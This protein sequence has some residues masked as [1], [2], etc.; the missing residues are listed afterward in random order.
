MVGALP[1]GRGHEWFVKGIGLQYSL[2]FLRV[3]LIFCAF[4]ISAP[5]L[6]Q[7][8]RVLF[9]K[10]V[11]AFQDGEFDEAAQTLEK[12][13]SSGY[14]TASLH[15]NLGVVYFR[16][17]RYRQS[18][19]AF[20]RLLDS[21]DER[22]ARYNLGLVA[23]ASGEN[24]RA[25]QQFAVVYRANP[26]DKLGRLSRRQLAEIGYD[27]E[28]QDEEKRDWYLL[29]AL[30]AG[31]EENIARLPDQGGTQ[32]DSGFGEA[33]LAGG[34]FLLG[35]PSGGL[36]ADASV[37]S[38]RYPG[39]EG[40]NTAAGQ[41]EIGWSLGAGDG[42]LRSGLGVIWYRLAGESRERRTR[43]ALRYR[44][45]GC[46]GL[47]RLERCQVRLT[48]DEIY[49][50]RGLRPYEGTRYAARLRYRAYW[51]AWRLGLTY[52]AIVNNREDFLASD[53]FISLSPRR[54][55]LEGGLRYRLLSN[56]YSEASLG[57]RY[58]RY[59]NPHIFLIKGT[60]VQ[61]TRKDHRLTY[62]L[63]LDWS[64]SKR[65]SVLLD[66]QYQDNISTLR[67]YEYDQQEIS[68]GVEVRF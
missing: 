21:G 46:L 53:R 2:S 42:I 17:E 38:R 3:A 39:E 31:Y 61:G 13:R 68:T 12:A 43:L 7:G 1:G 55:S 57:W 6:A 47:M 34:G 63:S 30:S 8:G 65:W 9:Q 16:L 27:F 25:L 23:V 62:G 20:R 14:D 48:A 15:Y 66:W 50:A 60:I 4:A 26:G 19:S 18:R 11:E 10:G 22:L 41:A 35:D 45:P 54:H 29:S 56:L 24:S 32:L 33:V 37:Y 52:E 28:Q 51:S 64:V 40:V 44:T 36:R 58:S 49:P 59:Q 5:S 67:R